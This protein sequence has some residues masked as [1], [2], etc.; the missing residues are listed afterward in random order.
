[1]HT[2]TAPECAWAEAATS[3]EEEIA[4]V[5]S[6]ATSRRSTGGG[7]AEVRGD[8]LSSLATERTA[9]AAASARERASE[10][11]RSTAP[12]AV[13]DAGQLEDGDGVSRGPVLTFFVGVS[14]LA[15]ASA[16]LLGAAHAAALYTYVRQPATTPGDV[17]EAATR[18]YELFFCLCVGVVELECFGTA[19][20]SVLGRSWLLRGVVRLRGPPRLLRGRE[21][22]TEA[23]PRAAARAARVARRCARAV[24][25]LSSRVRRRHV[26]RR[27]PLRAPRPLLLQEAQEAPGDRVPEA[28]RA[29]R[30]PLSVRRRTR[31]P[32]KFP[33]RRLGPRAGAGPEE[34]PSNG[35]LSRTRHKRR[36]PSAA[37]VSSQRHDLQTHI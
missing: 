16:G 10:E 36:P 22:R 2:P 27:R 12:A 31:E 37:P 1:M 17:I 24:R 7:E 13:E 4:S 6:K 26:R 3:D 11:L 20:H 18:L 33:V 19:T 32:P 28:P 25:G 35:A 14:C 30:T 29:K 23:R 34:A 5:A 15:I 21:R 8:D 9:L